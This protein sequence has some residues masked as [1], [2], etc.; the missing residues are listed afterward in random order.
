MNCLSCMHATRHHRPTD[1]AWMQLGAQPCHL[2]LHQPWQPADGTVRPPFRG[3]AFDARTTQPYG[4]LYAPIAQAIKFAVN[5]RSLNGGSDGG[6]PYYLITLTMA[7]R[8]YH[9]YK[10]NQIV[11]RFSTVVMFIQIVLNVG[12]NSKYLG[13]WQLLNPF[14]LGIY[15]YRLY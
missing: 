7:R 4:Q 12:S 8:S 11:N 5:S 2:D 9:S 15:R 13:F 1:V 6:S 3:V 10:S 14:V